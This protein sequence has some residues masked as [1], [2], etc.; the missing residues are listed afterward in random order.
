[1][2]LGISTFP[3]YLHVQEWRDEHASALAK[4]SVVE[5][6]LVL[7]HSVDRT[8]DGLGCALASRTNDAD[9]IKTWPYT[10]ETRGGCVQGRNQQDHVQLQTGL[11]PR[12]QRRG[13]DSLVKVRVALNLGDLA[14]V[15][16]HHG[17][18]HVSVGMASRG[19]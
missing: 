4:L 2:L 13:S 7:V 12:I 3:R 16:L 14:A 1:M 6:G 17:R 10:I 9:S 8:E 19:L 18:V 11:G 5:I 15:T